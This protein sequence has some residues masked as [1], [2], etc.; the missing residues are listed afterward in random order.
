M[1]EYDSVLAPID[2]KVKLCAEAIDRLVRVLTDAGV[3]GDLTPERQSE[4][5]TTWHPGPNA[6]RYFLAVPFYIH[7]FTDHDAQ[8]IVDYQGDHGKAP[9]NAHFFIRCPGSFEAFPELTSL[10]SDTIGV[11]VVAYPTR[12]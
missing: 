4:Y 10:V 12:D 11:R 2:P 5:V 1:A 6:K 8:T 3:I 7:L 9:V